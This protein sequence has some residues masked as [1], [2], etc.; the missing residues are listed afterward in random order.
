MNS[1]RLDVDT[2][3]E[4]GLNNLRDIDDFEE[5]FEEDKSL[6]MEIRSGEGV[7]V[8][9]I[10]KTEE[11]FFNTV[12]EKMIFSNINEIPNNFNL[13]I[14]L[15]EKIEEIFDKRKIPSY[16]GGGKKYYTIS[17]DD[18]ITYKR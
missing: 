7:F 3:M 13:R 15:K 6:K 2:L 10:L 14:K 9:K 12:Y 11:C 4:K 5:L 1:S 8:I 16:M 17:A 18:R